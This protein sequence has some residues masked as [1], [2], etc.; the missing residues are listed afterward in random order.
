MDLG[1]TDKIVFIAGA[2][3]GIGHGIAKSLLEEGAKVALT[4]RGAEALDLLKA[5]NTGHPGGLAT[6][7]PTAPWRASAASRT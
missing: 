1:L 2:S 5:W 6:P 3:R 7:T 4:A